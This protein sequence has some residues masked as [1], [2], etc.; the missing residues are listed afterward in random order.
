MHAI[1]CHTSSASVVLVLKF[2][3]G[4]GFLP[5]LA[6]VSTFNLVL[7]FGIIYNNPAH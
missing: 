6:R 2:S 3:F 1:A 4:F 5:K 7:T